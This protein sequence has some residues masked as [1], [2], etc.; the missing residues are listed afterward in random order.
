MDNPLSDLPLFTMAHLARKQAAK[1]RH[2]KGI[3][4]NPALPSTWLA[5]SPSQRRG[6]YAEIKAVHWLQ[7]QKLTI[8]T[9]NL[10]CKFGEI[11]IVAKEHGILVFIEV[12]SRSYRHFGD[13]A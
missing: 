2:P 5:V 1:S 4:P 6:K 8:L 12:R 9:T 13:A 10:R 11:D 3:T 7:Q